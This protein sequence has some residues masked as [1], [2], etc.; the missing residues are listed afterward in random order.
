MASYIKANEDRLVGL[1]LFAIALG[2]GWGTYEISGLASDDFVG[3][4]GFP[5]LIALCSILLA[6]WLMIRPDLDERKDIGGR[7]WIYWAFFLLY[8]AAMP[9]IGF[10]LSSALFLAA[11]FLVLKSRAWISVVVALVV[12]AVLL[13]VFGHIFELRIDIGPWG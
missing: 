7:V 3:P 1:I 12:V 5:G 2:Y 6:A 4:T 13:I 8:S 9:I 11:T 10:G